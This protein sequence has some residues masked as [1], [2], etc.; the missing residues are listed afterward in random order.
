MSKD[1]QEVEQPSATPAKK[2]KF[3]YVL[4]REGEL[5]LAF[6]G[7]VLAQDTEHLLN[8]RGYLT[9]NWS[10]YTLYST[11]SGKYAIEIESFSKWENIPDVNYAY[12]A[13][14]TQDLYDIVL[15]S[16]G[17]HDSDNERNRIYRL[18]KEANLHH[19]LVVEA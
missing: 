10:H 2:K 17:L 3:D 15:S 8:R 11:T 18:F 5:P 9:D 13:L 6:D 1:Y 14:T 12:S 19:D 7:D 16:D 4:K